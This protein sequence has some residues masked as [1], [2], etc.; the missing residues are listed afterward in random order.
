MYFSISKDV[1]FSEDELSH[2]A[3]HQKSLP[4]EAK[5]G[6]PEAHD[7]SLYKAKVLFHWGQKRQLST[8]LNINK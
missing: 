6:E 8:M 1:L 7:D 2:S 5:D 3:K 4:E